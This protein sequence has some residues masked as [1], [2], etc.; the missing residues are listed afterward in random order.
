[1]AAAANI[2]IAP[3]LV[4]AAPAIAVP[5]PRAIAI[6]NPSMFAVKAT[7]LAVLL[8]VTILE[9]PDHSGLGCWVLR[10]SNIH[11][12]RQRHGNFTY[13]ARGGT[14]VGG[15]ATYWSCRLLRASGTDPLYLIHHVATRGCEVNNE[16]LTQ[17]LDVS[18]LCDNVECWNPYHMA[19]ET[20]AQNIARRGCEGDIH[21]GN[22]AIV[23]ICPSIPKC[24]GIQNVRLPTVIAF[25]SRRIHRSVRKLRRM[26]AELTTSLGINNLQRWSYQYQNALFLP[27]I[28]YIDKFHLSYDVGRHWSG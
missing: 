8:E 17:A 24:V 23:H 16:F 3:P 27:N 26:I 6:N 15:G 5:P 9:N 25:E 21:D 12:L 22:G 2:P 10:P 11:R 1:M 18:H 7:M 13:A 4:P 19:S 20:R 28:N 14:L